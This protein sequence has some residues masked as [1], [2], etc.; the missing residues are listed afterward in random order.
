MA[1]LSWTSDAKEFKFSPESLQGGSLEFKWSSVFEKQF[2]PP[3]CAEEINV[4]GHRNKRP[5]GGCSDCA[6]RVA[7][8]GGWQ[9]RGHRRR[10]EREEAVV[11]LAMLWGEN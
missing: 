4:G 2:W 3:R 6:V 8:A 7:E 1:G 9:K 11:V 10:R 5:I